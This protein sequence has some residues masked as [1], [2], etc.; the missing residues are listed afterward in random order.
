M[1]LAEGTL[2]VM[3]RLPIEKIE[4]AFDYLIRETGQIYGA[5]VPDGFALEHEYRAGGKFY[6]TIPKGIL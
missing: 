4:S 5:L 6:L 3:A 1:T 2:C